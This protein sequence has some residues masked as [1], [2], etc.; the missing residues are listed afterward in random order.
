MSKRFL[1]YTA[2]F[3]I[4]LLSLITFYFLLAF[5]LSRISV[6]NK[7]SNSE[8]I[9]IYIMTN[10]IHTDIVVPSKNSLQD[11]TREIK[12]SHTL[13]A[14]SSYNYLAFGWG[15]K[16]FYLETPE[17]SDLKIS[18]ALRAIS[19]LSQSAMH[20]TFYKT[21][22][23]DQHCK[24]LHISKAQYQQLVEYIFASF[25]KDQN[26]N[27]IHIKTSIHYDQTDAFYEA[28]G[29]YSI[30]KTCNTWANSGLKASNQ[31]A[32]LWTIF[33]TPIFLKYK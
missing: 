27:F 23:E 4:G 30:L 11:R 12:Y 2:R 24:K 6:N 21:V 17:F 9:T 15:D 22:V 13:A 10:G 14:D 19:G 33:D 5:T 7:A 28:I 8:D 26:G 1:R 29:S 20:T 31:K 18:T 16:K 32:C 25:S 3:T